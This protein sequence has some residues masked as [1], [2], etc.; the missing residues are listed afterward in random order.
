MVQVASVA[1][2]REAVAGLSRNRGAVFTMGG[3]HEGHLE[4][5]RA[6]K[7]RNENVVASVFVNPKQFAAH[8][9]FGS[10][11]RTLERDLELLRREG[12]DLVFTPSAEEM[13]PPGFT[14]A[15]DPGAQFS[16]GSGKEG[17]AAA[18]AAA[19]EDDAAAAAAGG[20]AGEGAARPHFF[21]G[22]AT[23]CTRLLNTMQPSHAYFG[24]KD[25]VQCA[26]LRRLVA[27]LAMASE[28]I[29]NSL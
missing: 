23:V 5:V 26:V 17:G 20:G 6:A 18:A 14:T 8:E 29:S 9:D 12:V 21:R 4:L 2:C 1:A 28:V 27:D 3:L 11:P 22:V 16:S 24:Q 19:G 25:A 15:V 13:Y 10:Y 7:A